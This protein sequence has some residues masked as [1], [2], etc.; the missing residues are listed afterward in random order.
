MTSPNP[1]KKS[2]EPAGRAGLPAGNVAGSPYVNQIKA[3]LS[4][5]EKLSSRDVLRIDMGSLAHIEIEWLGLQEARFRITGHFDITCSEAEL[6]LILQALTYA[7]R[8]ANFYVSK[9]RWEE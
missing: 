7:C 6:R 4:E 2:A 9:W 1:V 3:I 5:T 8:N